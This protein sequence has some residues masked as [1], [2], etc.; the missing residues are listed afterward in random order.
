MKI[1]KKVLVA[2][3]LAGAVIAGPALADTD[4]IKMLEET[5][6]SLTQAIDTAQKHVG[7]KAYEASIDDD[8]AVPSYE[9]SVAK[10]GKTFDVMINGKTGEVISSN[11]DRW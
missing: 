7:G 11:E 6:V 3:A 10:D 4:D 2:S 5:S 8:G 1:A 9:V